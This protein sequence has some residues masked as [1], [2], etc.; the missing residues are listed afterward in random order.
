MLSRTGSP[1]AADINTIIERCMGQQPEVTL[2]GHFGYYLHDDVSRLI[3]EVQNLHFAFGQVRALAKDQ[4]IDRE[5]ALIL[6]A[7]LAGAI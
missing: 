6:I 5:D 1:M 2:G 3:A 7:D 4:T